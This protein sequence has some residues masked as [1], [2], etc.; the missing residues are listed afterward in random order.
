VLRR[1]GWNGDGHHGS[2]GR[3]G[4]TTA[5]RR[6]LPLSGDLADAPARGWEIG[7][8]CWEVTYVE[9]DEE[10]WR[11]HRATL[12]A[13]LPFRDFELA[14]PTR[15]AQSELA[16][17]TRATTLGEVTA[18]IAH[19]VSTSRSS[20]WLRWLAAERPNLELEVGRA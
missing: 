20:C 4:G 18:S 19:E 9:P 2:Q 13:H 12:E 15:G 5:E 3:R 16:H 17:V 6:A 8:T 7:K 1:R 11:Q 14:R 10:V